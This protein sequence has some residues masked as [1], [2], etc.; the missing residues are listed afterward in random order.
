MVRVSRQP[1]STHKQPCYHAITAQF[2]RDTA[3]FQNTQQSLLLL[4]NDQGVKLIQQ[5]KKNT[6][7]LSPL[8]FQKNTLKKSKLT[9]TF[10]VAG[11]W[12]GCP[13]NM[14]AH[15]NMVRMPKQHDGT[16]EQPYYH[17]VFSLWQWN[18]HANNRVVQCGLWHKTKTGSNLWL[19]KLK[20]KEKIN[21]F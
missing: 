20:A 16:H 3:I 13:S 19:V 9:A 6:V 12:S 18:L 1:D 4:D 8:H 5:H 21:S 14:T 15:K 11:Q 2:Q 17:T 7:T 10:L